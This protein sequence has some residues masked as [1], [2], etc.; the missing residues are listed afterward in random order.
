MNGRGSGCI[1]KR[2]RRTVQSL[3]LPQPS[4]SLVG[5]VVFQRASSRNWKEKPRHTSPEAES[6]FQRIT[7]VA[8][9]GKVGKG[10][11]NAWGGL[12]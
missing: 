4:D 9:H 2:R 3:I 5:S 11:A 12:A 10:L 7:E 8:L 1:R 6:A